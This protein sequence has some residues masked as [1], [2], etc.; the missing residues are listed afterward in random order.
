MVEV[1]DFVLSAELVAVTVTVV[2]VAT[3]AGAVYK[4]AA[5]MDPSLGL[6]T[7]AM[8]SSAQV[9]VELGNPVTAALNCCVDPTPTKGSAGVTVMV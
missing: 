1:A 2:L 9:T 8:P 4:P 6:F 7:G 5:V 3:V